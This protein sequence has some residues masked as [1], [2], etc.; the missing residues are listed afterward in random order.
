M[1]GGLVGWCA[2][3]LAGWWAGVPVGW[4]AGGM[5]AGG[6][7]GWLAGDMWPRSRVIGFDSSEEPYQVTPLTGVE[8]D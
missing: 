2:G 3:R 6:L 8:T 7:A 4:W 5:W 1:A